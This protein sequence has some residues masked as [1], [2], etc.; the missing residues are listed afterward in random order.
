M[1]EKW[2][3]EIEERG[4]K[5]GIEIGK[6]EAYNDAGFSVEAIAEKV[7]TTIENV[8]KVLGLITEPQ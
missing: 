8:K 4:E 2:I 1:A 5:R 6:I 3:D 7:G